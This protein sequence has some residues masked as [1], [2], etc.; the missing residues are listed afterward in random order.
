MIKKKANPESRDKRVVNVYIPTVAMR[1]KWKILAKK[2]GITFSKFIILHVQNS[3]DKKQNVEEHPSRNEIIT[4]LEKI[5]KENDTLRQRN[6][7]LD[8]IIHYHEEE[9]KRYRTKPFLEEEFSGKRDYEKDL[10]DL[11][12][13]KGEVRKEDLF[14]EL[15]VD[16]QDIE[17]VKGIRKQIQILERYGVLKDLGGKWRWKG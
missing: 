9:L 15:K 2:E 17:K 10:V 7:D 3:I 12:I 8:T 4:E 16:T 13:D 11:F 14:N 5:K 1:E 6:K